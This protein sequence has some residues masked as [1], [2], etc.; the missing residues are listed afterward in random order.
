MRCRVNRVELPR[1]EAE[2]TS[3]PSGDHTGVIFFGSVKGEGRRRARLQFGGHASKLTQRLRAP[4]DIN[5]GVDD[6]L[7]TA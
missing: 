2:A 7:F 5:I 4:P 6:L 1:M 3:F